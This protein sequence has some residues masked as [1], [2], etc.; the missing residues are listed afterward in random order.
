[1]KNGLEETYPLFASM[2]MALSLS[3][4]FG[5]FSIHITFSISHSIMACILL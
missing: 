3:G 5:V 4:L 2:A 1:M